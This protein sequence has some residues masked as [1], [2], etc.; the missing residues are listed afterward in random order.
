[1][2]GGC[3]CRPRACSL[4]CT[5]LLTVHVLIIVIEPLRS[6]VPGQIFEGEHDT[7]FEPVLNRYRRA[8][9]DLDPLKL[10]CT[11][12]MRVSCTLILFSINPLTAKTH[13]QILLCLTPDDFIVKGR[14]LDSEGVKESYQALKMG[15]SRKY[16]YRS[17]GGILEFPRERGV[18]WTGILKAW[19]AMQFRIP[20][21]WR[22]SA[23]NS[24]GRLQNLC[25]KS[26]ICKLSSL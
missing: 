25:T 17:T 12:K 14:P 11:L 9:G 4:H 13:L 21:A 18:S 24:F 26:P 2:I 22:V 3:Q 6:A 20:N 10:S 5:V 19:G 1:M 16:P 7:K 15:D 8:P 23:L